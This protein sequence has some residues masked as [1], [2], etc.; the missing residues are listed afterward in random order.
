[1]PVYKFGEGNN[2][3]QDE[4]QPGTWRYRFTQDG[5]SYRGTIHGA[6]TRKQAEDFEKKLRYE[7]TMGRFKDPSKEI[8]F[9][10]FVRNHY[11][12]A[13]KQNKKTHKWDALQAAILCQYFK[14]KLL[15]EIT[16]ADIEAY[17]LKRREETTLRGTAR[18]GSS[19]NRERALISVIFNYAIDTGFCDANPCTR[20]KRFRE[21]GR[22]TRV[23]TREEEARILA[24]MTGPDE[25][26]R[27][28][29]LLALNTGMRRGEILALRWEWFDF[30]RNE[31]N[32]PAG[33]RKNSDPLT[34]P[35][36]DFIQ[37]LL[38]EMRG[39]KTSGKLFPFTEAHASHR[40]KT[41]CDDL[42][43]PDVRLH[44]LRHTFATRM[45]ENGAHPF[46]VKEL[47]GHA[48][49]SQTHHYS[50]VSRT[51]LH[52]AVKMLETGAETS[53]DVPMSG[54]AAIS[55]AASV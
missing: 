9:E 24:A 34:V 27:P 31:I 41:I 40:M 10:D 18:A 48:R 2:I 23:V 50:H 14:G 1:M 35:L 15:R 22:R 46:V 53:P 44:V 30:D 43:M 54:E 21:T 29:V 19:V 39:E 6:T 16:T 33:I 28:I 12:K 51:E 47:M 25:K 5:K 49:T 38:I 26:I 3:L 4:R 32:F 36:N 45:L 52:K 55:A 42:G 13:A 37:A 17:K 20:V 8:T 11:L 7:I